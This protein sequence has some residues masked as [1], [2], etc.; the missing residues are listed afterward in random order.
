MR[1]VLTLT[2]LLGTGCAQAPSATDRPATSARP[3]SATLLSA[4]G[5]GS[6]GSR[7]YDIRI[8]P[9]NNSPPYVRAAYRHWL[10]VP[11]G[12]FS[13]RDA[14]LAD[15]SSVRVTTRMQP[16]GRCPVIAGRWSDPY[17]GMT[18]TMAAQLDVDHVVP[19]KEAHV[20]G[21]YAWT[22]A[23]RQAYANDLSNPNHLIAV[24]ATENRKKADKDPASYLPPNTRFHCEYI[25]IWIHIKSTWDLAMDP[26][27]AGKV[28]QVKEDCDRAGVTVSLRERPA[29]G[30]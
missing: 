25:A 29:L 16:N 15:E 7:L 1:W 3:D 17:S 26:I 28:R 11:G 12:C 21:G 23:K 10:K 4:S 18:F 14:V 2:L 6:I 19:L 24:S 13:V 5:P 30:E 22:P 20:S 8:E 27:E 9:E